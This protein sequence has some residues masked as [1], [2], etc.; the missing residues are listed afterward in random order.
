MEKTIISLP[1]LYVI[2]DSISIHYGPY[3]QAYLKGSMDY[4]RKEARE[5]TLLKL[6]NPQGDS[7]GDSSMVLSF[8]KGK[9]RHG[10]ID[11]DVLLLNCGLHDI[12][13][14]PVSGKI[15]VPLDQ[16][17]NNLREIVKIVRNFGSEIIWVRTTL[18]DDSIH[19]SAGVGFYRYAADCVEYNRVADRVMQENRIP[20]IDLC[21]FTL[22]LGN[23]LHCDHVHFTEIVRKKQAA[24]IA[25]ALKERFGYSGMCLT[26]YFV[27]F[28]K[29]LKSIF[30]A[31]KSFSAFWGL[32]R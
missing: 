27:S 22:N 24:Y 18:F 29:Y 23:D 32:R 31:H 10:G 11:A 15:Q 16:Y 7:G 8:L 20:A 19:N 28:V 26:Q 9:Q 25:S 21:T 17:E 13:S 5:E 14:D 4:S 1:K 12:K 2:G 30:K 3:L 6:D